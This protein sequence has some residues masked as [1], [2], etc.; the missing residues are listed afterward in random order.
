M[1]VFSSKHCEFQLKLTLGFNLLFQWMNKKNTSNL[2]DYNYDSYKE[3]KCEEWDES[4]INL[5]Y[6]RDFTF[7]LEGKTNLCN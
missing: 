6:L 4:N 7:L 2:S 1:D 5:Q 3:I